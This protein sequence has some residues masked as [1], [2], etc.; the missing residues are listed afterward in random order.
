MFTHL[1]AK[2]LTKLANHLL[3]GKLGHK[4][5]DFCGYNWS[6]NEAGED[7]I[8]AGCGTHGCAIGECPIAFPK[9]W[10][11]YRGYP[12]LRGDLLARHTK[13]SGMEFF[14]LT[15]DEFCYL[16]TPMRRGLPGT[17]TRKQ[18]ARHI[19]KFVKSKEVQ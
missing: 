1:H 4:V 12:V 9:Q 17:A 5:F 2:R 10:R 6:F 18:V 19:L 16:F 3:S 7:V 11:Y 15:F 13:E 14:G 8:P